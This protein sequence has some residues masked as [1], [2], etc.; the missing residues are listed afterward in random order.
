MES[1]TRSTRDYQFD[2]IKGIMII[3]VVLGHMITHL[4][5]GGLE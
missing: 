4:Y 3:L 5:L 2:N 1:V